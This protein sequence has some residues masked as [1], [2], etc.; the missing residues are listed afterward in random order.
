[1]SPIVFLDFK[2]CSA[3]AVRTA[4]TRSSFPPKNS[5]LTS[6]T[7]WHPPAAQTLPAVINQ[8]APQVVITTSW[9]RLM[10]RA[11]FEQLLHRTGL[12]VVANSLNPKQ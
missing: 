9:L 5:P 6:G 10:D 4:D 2:T 12:G 7:L 11:D 8:F 3:R 1:M